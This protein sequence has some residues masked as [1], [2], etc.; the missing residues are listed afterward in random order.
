MSYLRNILTNTATLDIDSNSEVYRALISQRTTAAS[1]TITPDPN[2]E[3]EEG[4]TFTIGPNE[5]IWEE[6]PVERQQKLSSFVLA[7]IL[8][9]AALAVDTQAILTP[10]A[11]HDLT[12][13]AVTY[14]P[15]AAIKGVETN[16][17]TIAVV[18]ETESGEWKEKE[19]PKV[20]TLAKLLFTKEVNAEKEVEKTITLEAGLKVKAGLDVVATSVHSGTGLVDPGGLVLVTFT[21]D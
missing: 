4:S 8:P 12:I 2:V 14:R 19:A 7:A 3:Y 21:Q 1:N 11:A 13:T 10:G 18:Y 5:P 6:V 9:A 17:R 15:N 20:P 16:S